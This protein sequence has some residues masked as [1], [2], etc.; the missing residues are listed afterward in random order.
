MTGAIGN[1]IGFS[2]SKEE[3]CGFQWSSPTSHLREH[4][5]PQGSRQAYRWESEQA[6]FA[7]KSSGLS[8]R[9]QTQ[10]ER[11]LA[12][13]WEIIESLFKKEFSNHYREDTA[14]LTSSPYLLAA[15]FIFPVML[16]SWPLSGKGL[17]INFMDNNHKETKRNNSHSPVSQ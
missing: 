12:P 7:P 15:L 10:Q 3:L 2:K 13:S 17:V 8:V 1:S 5:A 6:G 9:P 14:S 11:L 4:P 16:D